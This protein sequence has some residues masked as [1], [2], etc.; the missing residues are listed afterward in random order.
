MINVCVP[1]TIKLPAT[2]KSVE[3]VCGPTDVVLVRAIVVSVEITTLAPEP[4]AEIL[5]LI[6]EPLPPTTSNTEPPACIDDPVLPATVNDVAI[7]LE[8]TER[9]RPLAPI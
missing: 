1:V 7:V 2:V 6:P 5:V 4:L 8:V 3:I 9:I